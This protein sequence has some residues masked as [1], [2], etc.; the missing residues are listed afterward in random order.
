MKTSLKAGLIFALL[1]PYIAAFTPNPSDTSSTELEFAAGHGS[2]AKVSRDC[3]GHVSSVKDIPFSEYG[4]SVKHKTA[5]VVTFSAT[6]GATSGSRGD[7][8]IYFRSSDRRSEFLWYVTPT[9]GIDTK[10]FGLD[11]GC[12][13]PLSPAEK[14]ST[15]SFP[16]KNS[17][18]PM[19]ALRLGNRDRTYLSIGLGRNLPLLSGGGLFDAGLAF[20]LGQPS[21]RLWLGLGAYPYDALAF[22]AK[23]EFPLSGNFSLNPRLQFAF[24]ESFEYGLALGGKIIF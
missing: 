6:V 23:G 22:S 4:V 14:A 21:S 2:Y 13:I 16:S 5:S 3:Q 10:Y 24:G 8:F 7:P 19:G 17:P 18:F 12:L 9:V 11:G 20:P 1:F 15:L